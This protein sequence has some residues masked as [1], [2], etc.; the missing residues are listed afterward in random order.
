MAQVVPD[1][2]TVVK[3]LKFIDESG[4]HLGLTRLFARAAAGQRVVEA[5]PGASGTHYTLLATLG[6]HGVGAVGVLA[7]AVDGL[8]FEAY[9]QQALAPTL[10]KGDVVVLDNL[11]AHKNARVQALIEARGARVVFLP[12]YSPDF[13][14]IELCWAK[15]KS[16]LRSAKARTPEVLLAAITEAFA[17]ISRQDIHAWFAHCGYV[18]S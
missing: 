9:V 16:A 17:T 6:W 10:R 7:G 15:V 18:S 13:N 12:P 3:H 1:L 5:T 11:S 8:A 2:Q 14:P 4:T